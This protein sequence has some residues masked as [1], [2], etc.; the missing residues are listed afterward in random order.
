[1]GPFAGTEVVDFDRLADTGVYLLTGSTG[2]GKTT[3]LDAVSYALFGEIPRAAEGAEVVSHHR[4]PETLPEVKL[5]LTVGGER[6]RITRSPQYQR[7]KKHGEGTTT[8]KQSLLVERQAADGWTTESSMWKE[9]SDE[10][11][12]RVG[13]NAHQFSQ[14]AMLPQ[15]EFSRF[16]DAASR[17]RKELLLRLFPENNLG[18]LERWLGDEAGKAEDLREAKLAEIGNCLVKTERAAATAGPAGETVPGHDEPAPVLEWVGEI[19]K[20]LDRLS[21][22]AEARQADADRR[23]TEARNE[24]ERLR[25]RHDLVTERRKAEGERS[26]L[27]AKAGWLDEASRTLKAARRA[28]SIKPLG[29]ALEDRRQEA[30]RLRDEL[31][32]LEA[33]AEHDELVAGTAPDQRSAR[34]EALRDEA[35]ALDAFIRDRLPRQGE[36]GEQLEALAIEITG[37]EDEGPAS[38]AGKARAALERDREAWEKARAHHIEI[39]KARTEGMAFELAGKLEPDQPCPVCGSTEHPDPARTTDRVAS[40]EDEEKA[41]ASE[42]HHREALDRSRAALTDLEKEAGRRLTAARTERKAAL[43]ELDQLAREERELAGEALSL[44][45]HHEQVRDAADRLR[46]LLKTA[47]EAATAEAAVAE[48]ERRL[49]ATAAG[50]GFESAAA[51]LAAALPESGMEDLEAGIDRHR[52]NLAKLEGQLS[53]ELAGV[54]PAE[55]VDLA[56]AREALAEASTGLERATGAATLARNHL[57]TFRGET[58][59]LAGLYEELVPLRENAARIREL[60]RIAE[61]TNSQSMRLSNFLLAS[62]LQQVIECANRHLRRISDGRYNLVYTDEK[63]G[64]GAESGLGIKVLDAHTGEHRKTGTLSGGEKF[65]AA[66]SLALGLA[67][68]VQREAGSRSLET[69]FIDE[70]FGTL[71]SESLEKVMVVIDSL[72]EGGRSVGV[73]SH[74]EELRTRLPAQIRVTATPEGSTLKVVAG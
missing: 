32:A 71:D 31:A 24:V 19:T 59:P 38:P 73:V 27:E 72:R 3:V 26:R 35:L 17:D 50:Q 25:H 41:A 55:E 69:L 14:V 42:R 53:G 40:E 1:M 7:S 20:R 11:E 12:R 22:E 15:G 44:D 54:D 46:D 66:L 16:L 62:R 51:A 43:K 10:L 45:D 57:N 70:G 61:G 34:Q 4:K 36:L 67:E 37:L 58:E 5:E 8:Q 48:A 30:G 52:E 63:A 6:L 65:E 49:K 2:S 29:T 21:R 28:E 39:R 64:H 18:W 74:V 56:P 13:M 9:G 47:G 23:H 60:Q 68:V 33:W